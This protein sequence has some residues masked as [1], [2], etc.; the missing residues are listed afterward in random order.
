MADVLAQVAGNLRRQRQLHSVID[1]ELA[2]A[3][4][5]G[6]IMAALPFLA[7]GLGY[8]AGADPVAFL[9]GGVLG[10]IPL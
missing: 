4:T 8:L 2:A 1:A 6:H 3:R 10:Q 9:F 7:V 5:S